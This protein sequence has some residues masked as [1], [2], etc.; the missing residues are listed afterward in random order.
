MFP[1]CESFFSF[2]RLTGKA[3]MQQFNTKI[4]NIIRETSPRH[5]ADGRL[6]ILEEIEEVTEEMEAKRGKQSFVNFDMAILF[7]YPHF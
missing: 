6:N 5:T 7:R 4:P 2:Y 1:H 3:S